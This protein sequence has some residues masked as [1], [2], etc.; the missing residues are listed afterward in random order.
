[1]TS[2]KTLLIVEDN[3]INR[4]LLVEILSAQYKL[5]E[6]ENGQAALHVLKEHGEEI[7]LILL[8]IIMPVMDGYTFLSHVKKDPALAPIPVIVTTQG[9]AEKDE[10]NALSQGAA[11]FVTKPYNPQILLHRIANIINLQETAS[12]IKLFKYDRLTGLYAKEF[13]ARRVREILNANPD[14]VYD[15]ICSDI[16]N[17]KLVNELF[18]IRA[19]DRLLCGVAE[20]C[21]RF[22]GSEGVAGRIQADRFVCL[23]EHKTGYTQGMFARAAEELGSLSGTKSAAIKWGIYT[24]K[25]KELEVEQMCDRALL[26]AGSIKGQYGKYVAVY[27]D[28]L[29]SQLV[30][31][32]KIM[33][34]ME[35][36][37][38]GRQFVVYMQP[39]YR[40]S[41]NRLA[42]AEA[43]VRWEHPEWG[44]M[45]PG[46]FIPLFEKSGFI[47]RLDQFVWEDTC[48]IL[49]EWRAQGLPLVPVSVNVS[50]ADIYQADIAESLSGLVRKY[51]LPPSLLHLEITESAYTENPDQ[52]IDT[53]REL[54]RL[55]FIIEMD[56]FGSGYSSLNM[57]N[58]MPMDIL[59]LDLKFIQSETAKPADK[60]VLHFIM[61][62]ARWMKLLVIAEGVE[63]EAQLSRLRELGCDY[64]QGFYF[65]KPMTPS[66]F[67]K[68]LAGLPPT[69]LK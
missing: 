24:I 55:G 3:A 15:I 56:D 61:D 47:T 31:E 27:D 37:L 9:S 20:Q 19:G 59:K 23:K 17:F 1:M 42:G 16:E 29:R 22:A 46:S 43:L 68:L 8:D 69:E 13:F 49:Q 54:R 48:R 62:L 65:A 36:A 5:Y 45:M 14:K 44:M 50:R 57:L 66:N 18:G 6:A 34:S 52:I 7:D 67:Q 64:V 26:A 60:G 51:D 32:Q 58:Q 4:Q 53:V 35:T 30:R 12:M 33:E 41:D 28:K 39:K 38:S 21:R 63:T 10:I 2:D 11:D 40:V 25:N